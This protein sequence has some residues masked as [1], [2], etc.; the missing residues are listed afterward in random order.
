MLPI[1]K[2]FSG[3][4]FPSVV[5]ET[6]YFTIYNLIPLPVRIQGSS[7]SN[8]FRFLG[9]REAAV[10]VAEKNR[11]GQSFSCMPGDSIDRGWLRVQSEPD[12]TATPGRS[13]RS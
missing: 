12:C 9:P 3:T 11:D 8:E 13:G 5:G 10:Q 4:Q 6:E 7:R 1:L 2:Q